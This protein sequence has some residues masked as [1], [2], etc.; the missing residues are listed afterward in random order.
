MKKM[1]IFTWIVLAFILLAGLEIE[2]VFGREYF[3]GRESTTGKVTQIRHL[4]TQGDTIVVDSALVVRDLRVGKSGG[5]GGGATFSTTVSFETVV[6]VDTLGALS[7]GVIYIPDSLRVA[8]GIV[9]TQFWLGD[10]SQLADS[11]AQG[12]VYYGRAAES[13]VA[14]QVV[15][16][17]GNGE[18]QLCDA[19]VVGET[20]ALAVCMETI[21][22][23][24]YGKFAFPG[25]TIK[26][27]GW[28]WTPGAWLYVSLTTGA[29]T[30]TQVS[31][32][33]DY[34]Q[35]IGYA[36]TPD[37]IYFDPD[38]TIIKLK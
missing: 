25:C 27:T 8:N 18:F 17:D 1:L 12:P 20:K 6:Y 22:A 32:A 31:A 21:G 30:E 5:V 23:D 2:V 24:G 37:L 11:T 9:G 28:S 3:E 7:H 10:S 15:F 33:D 4:Y 38:L 13:L 14:G 35:K 36:I 34:S 29:I 26:M 16:P 19:D